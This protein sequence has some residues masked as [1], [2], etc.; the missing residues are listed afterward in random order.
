MNIIGINAFH[1]DASACLVQDGKLVFAVEEERY[2]RKKHAAGFPSEALRA[3]LKFGGLTIDQID[4]IAISRNPS[5][6]LSKKL[7]FTLRKRPSISAIVDRLSNA[8]KVRKLEDYIGEAVGKPADQIKAKLHQVEHHRAHLA[9]AFFVSPF[10]QAACL[11]IDGFGDFVST[12]MAVGRGTDIEVLDQVEYPHSCG[13][14]YSAVTQFIGYP[15]YGEEWKVMGLAPYGKPTYLPQMRQILK[16]TPDGKFELNLDYFTHHKDG[17][18]MSWDDGTPSMGRVWSDKWVETFGPARKDSDD[19]YGKW[20]DMAA[21]CQAVYEEVFF[22]I[23][24]SLHT[25]TKLD[26]L[27]LAG[28]CALNSVANGKITENTPF[29]KVYIQPAAGDNGTAIGAAYHAYHVDEKQ[30]RSGFVMTHAYTGNGYEEPEVRAAIDLAKSTPAWDAGVTVTQLQPD[31]LADATAK[32]VSEGRIVGWFQGRME[33][34]P[35]ALG[36]RSI[37]ADPRRLDMKDILNTRIKRRETYRPFAPSVLVERVGDYYEKTEPS[38]FMLMVYKTKEDARAKIPAVNH[39]D[40]TGRLQTVTREA[41][42]RYHALISAF[43]KQTGVG[44]V[45]NT[46]FNENEPIV[47]TPKEALDCFLRTQ[48]DVLAIGDYFL[49]RPRASASGAV[50]GAVSG[51]TAA[52]KV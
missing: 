49:E 1:G 44:L 38:P 3:C 47:N 48:M 40:N 41:S 12:M 25:R 22:S 35:R 50:T 39:V 34:G 33:F 26:T 6:N 2:N 14:F 11:S 52:A 37:V 43:E 15:K 21:S 27:C 5:A 46:S 20:A 13:L 30:P 23:L 32:A 18:E 31:A 28:G 24:K 8:S 42:P 19:F 7:L 9:S 10:D 45:L 51:T 16:A 17:V 4:H 36:G 29:K